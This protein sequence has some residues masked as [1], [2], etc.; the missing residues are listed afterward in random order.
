MHANGMAEAPMRLWY[1]IYENA[2]RTMGSTKSQMRAEELAKQIVLLCRLMFEPLPDDPA[3]LMES[4]L[5]IDEDVA[6]IVQREL[7]AMR[8]ALR[9]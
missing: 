3:A 8:N 2:Q 6:S 1:A 5:R 9:E 7:Q 4:L